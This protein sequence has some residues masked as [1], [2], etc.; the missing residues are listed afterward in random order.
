MTMMSTTFTLQTLGD[1]Q[2]CVLQH[3]KILVT[4]RVRHAAHLTHS[5]E[6]MCAWDTSAMPAPMQKKGATNMVKIIEDPQELVE[7]IMR[8][9]RPSLVRFARDDVELTNVVRTAMYDLLA[10]HSRQIMEAMPS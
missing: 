6:Q 1:P 8:R 5:H 7:R 4:N 2:R 3:G 10:E 9:Y